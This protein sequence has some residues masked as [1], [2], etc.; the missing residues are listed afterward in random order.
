MKVTEDVAGS[1]AKW[2]MSCPWDALLILFNRPGATSAGMDRNFEQWI[3]EVERAIGTPEFRW[4][5]LLPRNEAEPPEAFSV[6]LGGVKS[7]DFS[8]WRRRW[9]VISGNPNGRRAPVF[10]T[11]RAPEQLLSMMRTL[12]AEVRNLDIEVRI[13]A[14]LIGHERPPAQNQD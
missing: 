6:L 5:R 11:G 10:S 12:L 13:G 4:V 9:S 14:R 3:Q 7:E 8:R 1:L 2:C